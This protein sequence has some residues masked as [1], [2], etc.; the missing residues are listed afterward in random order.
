ML[1]VA[2]VLIATLAVLLVGGMSPTGAHERRLESASVTPAPLPGPVALEGFELLPAPGSQDS[3]QVLWPVGLALVLVAVALAHRPSRRLFVAALA[4]VLVVFAVESA[5]H[6]VHHTFDD[7]PV[8]CPTALLA[9]QL[10]GAIVET[11]ALEVPIAVV[12]ARLD[13]PDPSVS[14][15]CPLDPQHGRAPP[16]ALV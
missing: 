7:Q 9:A 3:R 11:P 15:L 2:T 12:A 1:R 8:A 10:S 5:L 16:S 14:S 4:I 6:S 13:A